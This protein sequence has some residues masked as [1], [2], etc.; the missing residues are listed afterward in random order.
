MDLEVVLAFQKLQEE[1]AANG[2]CHRKRKLYE[3]L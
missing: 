1:E 3:Q 2:I